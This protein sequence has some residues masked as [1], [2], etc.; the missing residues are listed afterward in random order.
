MR[1]ALFNAIY[2]TPL[3]PHILGGA[4]VLL[5]ILAERLVAAGHE[6]MVVRLANDGVRCSEQVAGVRVEFV[7]PR[8]LFL[9]FGPKRSALAHV[10]WHVVDDWYRAHSDVGGLLDA[11][12]PDVVNT[13]TLN[14]L[15]AEIW[16]LARSRRLPLVH[17]LHDYYLLCPR[18]SRAKGGH[19][20]SRTCTECSLLTLRRRMRSD[21]VQA[22]VSVSRRTLDLHLEVGL[23]ANASQHV[24]YN[25]AH[26]DLS[27]QPMRP[28]SPPVTIGY[29][30]RF[31]PEKGVRPL[32]EAV[33]RLPRGSV[34]LVLAGRA[35][36]EERA[37]LAA[38]ASGADLEFMG[39]VTPPQFYARVDVAVV[40]S[41]WEEPGALV[42]LD[43]LRAGRPVVLTRF[44]GMPEMIQDGLNGW[45]APTAD[46]EGLETI[47]WR[48]VEQPG[49][50]SAAH[51]AIAAAQ[52]RR[53]EDLVKEY[54]SVYDAVRAA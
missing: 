44:G 12:R 39:F 46:V 9:P 16:A 37:A 2:P 31:S 35:S 10:A 50:L 18:C 17:T 36:E 27:L 41:L 42:V 53:P 1:I 22:V 30:G 11:F 48:I 7:P 54:L 23:F 32:V 47:L 29:M 38:L 40:P 20:C 33:S 13:H 6:V 52:P 8:N 26:P 45:I 28:V 49:L 14:G 34:R 51:A 3:Q 15:S 5:R 4:E 24:I 21:L 25:V 19:V 43:A